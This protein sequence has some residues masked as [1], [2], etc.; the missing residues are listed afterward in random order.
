TTMSRTSLNT[1]FKASICICL[2]CLLMSVV[3]CQ[4]SVVSCPAFRNGPRTTDRLNGYR[5]TRAHR[6]GDG[7]RLHV[8]TLDARR[9][10]GLHLVHE[11][12]D[13]VGQLVLLEAEL[14]NAG[15]DVAALV[16]AILD[17]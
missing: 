2:I 4:L 8:V 6:R 17:L 13:V 15:V 1:V 12:G 9:L 3:S 14:A 10:G 16:G 11:G 7:N 5:D